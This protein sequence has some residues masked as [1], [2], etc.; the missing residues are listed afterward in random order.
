MLM[1]TTIYPYTSI[2][3]HEHTHIYPLSCLVVSSPRPFMSEPSQNR[4]ERPEETSKGKEQ[5]SGKEETTQEMLCVCV[6][7]SGKEE[8]TQGAHH[9]REEHTTQEMPK[10]HTTQEIAEEHNTPCPSATA[11]VQQVCVAVCCSVLQCVAVWCSVVQSIAVCCS[12][13]QCDAVCCGIVQYDA[14]TVVVAQ[15]LASPH[16]CAYE[17][18]W[19]GGVRECEFAVSCRE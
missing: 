7:V 9:T 15:V 5:T 4:W 11:P 19:R 8:M 6:C 18:R 16:V 13:L 17:C 1:C 14:T 3:I 10:E 12:M 2:H